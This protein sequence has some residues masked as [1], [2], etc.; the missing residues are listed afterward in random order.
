MEMDVDFIEKSHGFKCKKCGKPFHITAHFGKDW[1][2]DGFVLVC[3]C[4]HRSK[5]LPSC[6]A[7]YNKLVGDGNIKKDRVE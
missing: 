2:I 7:A 5:V 4:G 1:T 3:E 6:E